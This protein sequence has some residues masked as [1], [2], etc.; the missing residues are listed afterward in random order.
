MQSRN[1]IQWLLDN[2]SFETSYPLRLFLQNSI[3]YFTKTNLKQLLAFTGFFLLHLA[4]SF[5][6]LTRNASA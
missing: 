6:P 1:G 2:Y 5:P 3:S 4:F